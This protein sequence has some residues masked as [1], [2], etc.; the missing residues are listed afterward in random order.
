[1]RNNIATT[2]I[3]VTYH[4]YIART[5]RGV[6]LYSCDGPNSEYYSLSP[7]LVT[8]SFSSRN[9]YNIMSTIAAVAAVPRSIIYH[10][11]LSN[12]FLYIYINYIRE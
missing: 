7:L 5:T 11:I 8:Q 1:M 4:V 3:V 6:Y 12:F 2:S 9:A 10:V